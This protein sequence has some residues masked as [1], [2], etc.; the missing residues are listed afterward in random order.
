MHLETLQ[1]IHISS[2]SFEAKVTIMEKISLGAHLFH[3]EFIRFVLL[4]LLFYKISHVATYTCRSFSR[5]PQQKWGH[6]HI[7]NE[8]DVVDVGFFFVFN[9]SSLW[10]F[11]FSLAI[12]TLRIF[13]FAKCRLN[14]VNRRTTIAM[15]K[16]I[17]LIIRH[18]IV[19]QLEAQSFAPSML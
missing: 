7:S 16:L 19:L 17:N 6:C 4:L 2:V 5:F 18:H 15:S 3:V 1:Q 14:S 12:R 8:F 9:I 10:I 11:F 13:F